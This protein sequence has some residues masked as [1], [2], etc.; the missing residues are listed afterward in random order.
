MHHRKFPASRSDHTTKGTS[1]C[2]N[3]D[4]P[5]QAQPEPAASRVSAANLMP[6]CVGADGERCTA[7]AIVE[8]IAEPGRGRVQRCNHQASG[9][10]ITRVTTKSTGIEPLK[11]GHCNTDAIATSIVITWS[12]K[13][14]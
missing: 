5:D 7:G 11:T 12:R 10:V 6:A 13:I 3:Y 8:V 9:T 1:T 14:S 2:S 4:S